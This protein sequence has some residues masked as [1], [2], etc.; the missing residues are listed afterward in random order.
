MGLDSGYAH[1]RLCDATGSLRKTVGNDLRDGSVL[2]VAH[3]RRRGLRC[4]GNYDAP[5]EP[6]A[7]CMYQ[8]TPADMSRL[9][10]MGSCPDVMAWFA[11]FEHVKIQ[12]GCLCSSAADACVHV[13]YKQPGIMKAYKNRSWSKHTS[14]RAIELSFLPC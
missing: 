3:M 7:R 6:R 2:V 10:C 9:V 8:G 5:L 13:W 1:S 11:R 14:F 4:L 12:L